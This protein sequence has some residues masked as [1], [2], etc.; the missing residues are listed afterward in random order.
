MEVSS[1]KQVW[2]ADITYLRLRQ[3]FAYLSLLTD[4]YSRKIVGWQVSDSL[5]M[6]G[7]L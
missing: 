6:E 3:E 1:P 7:N 5:G 2:V 4:R